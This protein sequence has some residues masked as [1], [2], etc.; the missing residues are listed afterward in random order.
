MISG[1]YQSCLL[2]RESSLPPFRLMSDAAPRAD[3]PRLDTCV[4]CKSAA[5]G[6]DGRSFHHAVPCGH[7]VCSRCLEAF[8]AG[9]SGERTVAAAASSSSESK[10]S[11]SVCALTGCKA[12]FQ[13]NAKWPL[14]MC[15]ERGARVGRSLTNAFADQG[16]VQG[17]GPTPA[18]QDEH[19]G[20]DERWEVC[21]AHKK[22]I[23]FVAPE[24]REPELSL[25]CSDCLEQ[26]G[27]RSGVKTAAEYLKDFTANDAKDSIQAAEM[28]DELTNLKSLPAPF[29]VRVGKWAA[30]ETSRIRAWEEREVKAVRHAADACAA[31]VEEIRARWIEVGV[32]VLTQ[33]VSL[34]VSL[35][36]IELRLQEL[37]NSARV[38]SLQRLRAERTCLLNALREG[39]ISLIPAQR[40]RAWAGLPALSR[41]SKEVSER[42]EVR[43]R[44]HPTVT[45]EPCLRT[46]TMCK[47]RDMLIQPSNLAK[48]V[49]QLVG[50]RN[51]RAEVGI[52][53]S[54]RR[55]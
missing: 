54:Q 48:D 4:A 5:P 55:C 25:L 32:S 11:P 17:D 7:I 31:M 51:A 24:S 13:P 15:A 46:L 38:G 30:E 14:A 10:E 19:A 2:T 26:R 34:Q 23:E 12:I 33:R 16:D 21:A 22:A 43:E 6:A 44:L 42:E 53:S 1:V 52:L 20:A 47:R 49:P 3:F 39:G 37:A 8:R 45:I 40:F 41:L 35:K 27:D 9:A 29:T 18:L 36:E 50:L 28:M